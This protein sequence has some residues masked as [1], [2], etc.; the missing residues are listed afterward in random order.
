MFT[1]QKFIILFVVLLCMACSKTAEPVIETLQHNVEAV[2]KPAVTNIYSGTY[3]FDVQKYRDVQ[4]NQQDSLFKDMKPEDIEKMMRI[5]KPFKIEVNGSEAQA[6]FA[7]DVIKGRLN[8]LQA[9]QQRTLLNMIPV[10]EDK[11]DQAVTLIIE[12]D[13]LVLDPGKR[14]IDKMYFTR[15]R[16]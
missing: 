5:F 1:R 16:E 13:Q 11:Q 15:M 6:T 12:G 2:S 14:E 4:M 8:T 9:S 10:D 7:Q 3:L